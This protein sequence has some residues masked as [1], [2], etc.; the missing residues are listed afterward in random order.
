MF[1]REG[2]SQPTG[3]LM[4]WLRLSLGLGG[5]GPV[6]PS[7]LNSAAC[8]RSVYALRP[9]PSTDYYLPLPIQFLPFTL[10]HF[11]S[12]RASS[13]TEQ[14]S[15]S[16]PLILGCW[17]G[18]QAKQEDTLTLADYGGA[19]CWCWQTPWGQ[20]I[21][22]PRMGSLDRS[23][24]IFT[25][26]FSSLPIASQQCGQEAE[27]RNC[28]D[29]QVF[30]TSLGAVKEH[31]R[32]RTLDWLAVLWWQ[33]FVILTKCSPVTKSSP[34]FLL[35]QIKQL[36]MIIGAKTFLR[37]D[38]MHGWMDRDMYFILSNVKMGQVK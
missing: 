22:W 21:A 1:D 4:R 2:F 8:E 36:E 3:W 7:R 25:C 14:F 28:T 20:S 18:S 6:A 32:R 23:I 9:T 19:F 5:Y 29:W 12:H 31:L 24:F 11:F 33:T 34:D 30:G 15:S 13:R 37:E 16:I 26:S 35:C 38:H 27:F 10:R 17:L